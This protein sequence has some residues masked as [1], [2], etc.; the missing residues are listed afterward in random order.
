MALK[1]CTAQFWEVPKCGFAPGCSKISEISHISTANLQL[2]SYLLHV[3][4]YGVSYAVMEVLAKFY[5]HQ[6]LRDVSAMSLM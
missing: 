1:N 4:R 3:L 2:D 5:C 6:T